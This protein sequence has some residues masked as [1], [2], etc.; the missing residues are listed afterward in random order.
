MSRMKNKKQTNKIRWKQWISI[1][2]LL[3]VVGIVA[4]SVTSKNFL[5]RN[6]NILFFPANTPVLA[7]TVK[8]LANIRIGTDQLF[9]LSLNEIESNLITYPWVDHVQVSK[10]FPD[11]VKINVYFRK[12]VFLFK[13]E[14]GPLFYMDKEAKIFGPVQSKYYYN[15]PVL[16]GFSSD[17]TEYLRAALKFQTVWEKMNLESRFELS[18]IEWTPERGFRVFLLYP[19]QNLSLKGR[20]VLEFGE[21]FLEKDFFSKKSLNINLKSVLAYLSQNQVLAEKIFVGEGKKIVVKKQSGS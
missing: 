1:F 12:P 20:T 11:T 19:I 21:D 16:F 8:D 17:Q 14:K 9:F 10:Q 7:E 2:I 3:G 6:V 15:L 5:V 18:S 4:F 13:P